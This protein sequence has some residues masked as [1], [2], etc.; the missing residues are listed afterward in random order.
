MLVAAG[1][2]GYTL[3]ASGLALN[4][5]NASFL[6]V[7]GQEEGPDCINPLV[8]DAE[9]WTCDCFEEMQ[10]V[11]RAL[12][13]HDELCMRAHLCE[14]PRICYSWKEQACDEPE[15]QAMQALVSAYA[16][17]VRRALMS[18]REGDGD[19]DEVFDRALGDKAC[20]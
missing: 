7:S 15:I 8:Q 17:G 1:V 20:L 5:S 16:P 4:V 11:C 14:H 2:G 10:S 13:P 19:K 18:R 6:P 9:S 3:N 12:G